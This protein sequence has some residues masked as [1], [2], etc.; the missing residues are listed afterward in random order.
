MKIPET[1]DCA[2]LI[3]DVKY[4]WQYVERLYNSLQR[5]LSPRVT[6]HVYTEPHRIVPGHMIHH[7]L[8]E[9]SGIRGPKRSWWYKIQLFNSEHHQGPLLYLDLDTVV[10]NNIDWIW[11]LPTNRF[12]AVKDFKYLFN[13]R[14]VTMNSSVMWF[15]PSKWNHVYRDFDP[16]WIS[17]HRSRWHGDQD[18][19]HEKIDSAYINYFDTDRVRSWRWELLD[20]GF[21][22]KTRRHKKPGSGTVVDP[23]TSIL[24]FHGDPKP[25]EICD[26]TVLSHW[27]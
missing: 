26:Q 16:E 18:Y 5:N 23:G 19:I 13:H 24:V 9:W 12:W 8:D 14:R 7:R 11:Q 10:V 17:K 4:Q 3:H 1:I 25:H 2:C 21:D 22:F 27:Y 20:G 15:D 6:M